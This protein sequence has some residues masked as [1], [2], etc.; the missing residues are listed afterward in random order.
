LW[1][2]ACPRIPLL[3]RAVSSTSVDKPQ[4]D[5]TVFQL[6]LLSQFFL[7][8]WCRVW[9]VF[10]FIEP[11]SEDALNLFG[12][13]ATTATLFGDIVAGC[14]KRITCSAI[15]PRHV[16]ERWRAIDVILS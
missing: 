4:G 6:G 15:A 1:K 9:V 13:P 3:S 11:G 16:R 7:L 8:L 5:L 10:V 14:W 2:V 12:E